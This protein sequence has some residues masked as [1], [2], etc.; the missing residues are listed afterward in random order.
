[1]LR[2]L[3]SLSKTLAVT[4]VLQATI[5]LE[6]IIVHPEKKSSTMC[7][8]SIGV[9]S[10]CSSLQSLV[11]GETCVFYEGFTR[12]S[13]PKCAKQ[14]TTRRYVATRCPD[15]LACHREPQVPPQDNL[16]GK[17]DTRT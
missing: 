7:K 10:G 1:M 13:R 8:L 15:H 3:S 2:P 5:Q 9:Y 17:D 14:H 4:C 12:C 6:F 11:W 16:E